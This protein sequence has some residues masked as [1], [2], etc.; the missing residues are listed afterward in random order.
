VSKLARSFRRAGVAAVLA[1]GV[2]WVANAAE[3]KYRLFAHRGGV[4]EDRFP[5]NSAA[6]LETAVARGYWALEIDIR[7]TQDGVLVMQHDPDLKLN[8]GD[9]RKIVECTWDDIRELRT[10]VGEHPLWR[11]EDVV[12]AARAAGLRLMLDSK[13]P[14]GPE[15]CAKIERVLREHDMLDR[16]YVIGTADALE[17]FRGKAPVGLKARPLRARLEADPALARHYFLFDEGKMTEDTVRWAQS[18]GLEIVPSIN[19]QHYYDHATMAGKSREELAPIILAAAKRDVEK[20]QALGVTAFQIDSEFDRWFDLP[21]LPAS[22][23]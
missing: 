12:P 21:P 14:H 5:D 15:F 23:P 16:C 3:P 8:F 4:V 10:T 18:L 9:A 11:F 22:S 7:E 19:T 6:A 13:N 2:T 20:F 1:F 17:H